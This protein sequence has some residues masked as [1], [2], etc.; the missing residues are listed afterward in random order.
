MPVSVAKGS[1]V[2]HLSLEAQ[3]RCFA[4]LWLRFS[5][6]KARSCVTHCPQV[7]SCKR[8]GDSFLEP[9]NINNHPFK[10]VLA[11]PAWIMIRKCGKWRLCY[12]QIQRNRVP[13]SIA[14]ERGDMSFRVRLT[15][16]V[17][18][19]LG[20][21]GHD[22]GNE[23]EGRERAKEGQEKLIMKWEMFQKMVLAPNSAPK[24]A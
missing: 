7:L 20:K 3:A 6:C 17:I 1:F 9:K 18:P 8:E 12:S 11:G 14:L 2:M 10:E 13:V 24:I 19:E 22:W 5:V 15:P 16:K 21:R 4:S 23:E